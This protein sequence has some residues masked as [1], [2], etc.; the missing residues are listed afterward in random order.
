[1]WLTWFIS[2]STINKPIAVGGAYEVEHRV[3]RA[4]GVLE[5]GEEV[6]NYAKCK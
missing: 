1:M 5:D 6:G 2:L 4:G 3:L